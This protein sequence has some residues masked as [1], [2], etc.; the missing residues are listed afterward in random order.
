MMRSA[1]RVSRRWMFFLALS[2]FLKVGMASNQFV[3]IYFPDGQS[4]RA[5]LAVTPEERAQGLMFRQKIEFDQGM[6]FVFEREGIYS[7]WMKNM[8]VYLDLI[9]LDKEKRIV[10]V[11]REVP[12]CAEEPCPTYASNVPALYVLELRA[13]SFEKR[14][15]KMFDRLDFI[16]PHQ[17]CLNDFINW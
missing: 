12:P 9:W 3:Q 4:V 1:R 7:F 17:K 11:E 8:A 5:E 13:G 14:G 6:L 15:L 16:L 10:H 2:T